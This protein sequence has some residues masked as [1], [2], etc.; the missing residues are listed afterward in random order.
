[1]HLLDS[2]RLTGPNLFSE[3]PGA[4]IDVA[5]AEDDVEL[6]VAAWRRHARRLLDDLEWA[7]EQLVSRPF[8]GGVSL[9]VSAPADGLYTA[10]ELNETA[11]E[12]ARD[13]L[14]GTQRHLLRRAARQLRGEYRDEERPRLQR[15]LEAAKEHATPV[16]LDEDTLTLGPVRAAKAGIC[17]SSPTRMT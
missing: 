16:V 10:T 12:A 7:E 9:A 4:V 14:E 1:M 3:R 5:V 6:L 15:L 2:R 11:W 13:W 8:A 17:S